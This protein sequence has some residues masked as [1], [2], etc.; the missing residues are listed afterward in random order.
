MAADRAGAGPGLADAAFQQQQVYH[1]LD[2]IDGVF[3]LGQAHGPAGDDPGLVFQNG[4]R[5]G[6]QGFIYAAL[7]DECVQ[8]EP[9]EVGGKIFII[10]GVGFDKGGVQHRARVQRL[11]AKQ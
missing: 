6:Y 1:F 2:G 4:S 7:P 3:M 8:V 5:L 9:L 10:A 11:L